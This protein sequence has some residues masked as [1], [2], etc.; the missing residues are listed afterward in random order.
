MG[1]LLDT[2][3]CIYLIK[4]R[5]PALL[6]KLSG[7]PLDSISISSVTI[8]ELQYGVDKSL[9]PERNNFALQ[10]F[11]TPFNIV[12]FDYPSAVEYGKIRASLEKKGTPIGPM[13]MLI[14][15]CAKSRGLTVVS[16]NI[17]EFSRVEGL[18]LENWV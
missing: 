6:E 17:R 3:I 18:R 12:D 9:F 15:A 5:S 1:Y 2:N 13:D 14:A 11:L 4:K 10:K 8:A 7:F 16:N